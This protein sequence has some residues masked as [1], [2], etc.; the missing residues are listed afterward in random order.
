MLEEL[1]PE[2][3]VQAPQPW[4]KLL[5]SSCQLPYLLGKDVAHFHRWHKTVCNR[6]R[7]NGCGFGLKSVRFW[8]WLKS[9][10]MGRN[11]CHWLKR[12]GF[13]LKSVTFWHWIST[14]EGVGRARF[15]ATNDRLAVQQLRTNQSARE[16]S[17]CRHGPCTR[18]WRWPAS[19]RGRCGFRGRTANKTQEKMNEQ[20]GTLTQSRLGSGQNHEIAQSKSTPSDR[21]RPSISLQYAVP[22]HLTKLYY[23]SFLYERDDANPC[24]YRLVMCAAQLHGGKSWYCT[25][26]GGLKRP[27]AV[28]MG[29]IRA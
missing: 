14:L 18:H 13:E 5:R 4:W 26:A 3:W 17:L 29:G 9:C 6:L 22:N 11:Q 12:C 27:R 8:H 10:V 16:P 20:T 15:A 25:D 28:A 24:R 21:L 1:E 7:K 19:Q 2:I 23:F